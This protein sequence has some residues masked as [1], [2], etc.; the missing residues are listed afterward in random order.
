MPSRPSVVD[1]SYLEKRYEP[2]P[3]C[4][5]WIWTGALG[6]SGYGLVCAKQDKQ[7]YAHRVMWRLTHGPIPEGLHILHRCD[8]PLCVNPAHLFLGTNIDNIRD[9]V[10]KGRNNRGERNGHAKLTTENVLYIRS[11]D[12]P[13]EVLAQELGVSKWAVHHVRYGRRWKHL[14]VS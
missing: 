13:K 6:T 10:Q 2:V 4:G 14:W 11:S 8:V 3:E 12:K 7:E 1:A 9:C 5:C